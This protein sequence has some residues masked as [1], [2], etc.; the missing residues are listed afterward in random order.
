MRTPTTTAPAIVPRGLRF[1][2]VSGSDANVF[3][4]WVAVSANR[5]PTRTRGSPDATLGGT[6]AYPIRHMLTGFGVWLANPLAFAVVGA[7]AVSWLLFDR[8]SFDWQ[9]VAT[10]ATWT[11]TLFIQRAEHRDTLAIQ[12]KLDELLRAERNASNELM[13]I[14]DKEPEEIVLHRERTRARG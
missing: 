5:T 4:C 3:T 2:M 12:A 1:A 13:R 11:M 7:Y 10:V 6:M 14:D 8:A 9:G